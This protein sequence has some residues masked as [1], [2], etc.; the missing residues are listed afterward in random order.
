MTQGL[1]LREKGLT[2]RTT[3]SDLRFDSGN[4]RVRGKI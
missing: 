3:M 4:E 2:E 1:T